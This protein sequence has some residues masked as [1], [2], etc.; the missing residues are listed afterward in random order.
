MFD[1][2]LLKVTEDGQ[3]TVVENKEERDFIQ[4]SNRKSQQSV[5]G[6]IVEDNPD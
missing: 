5:Q 4:M 1:Q 3:Y 6:D 2:G